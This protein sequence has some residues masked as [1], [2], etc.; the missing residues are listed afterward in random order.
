MSESGGKIERTLIL[1]ID[2][3]DDIGKKGDV[4]TPI[5]S[6]NSNLEAATKLALSDP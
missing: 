2:V 3:D 4:E 5:L 6:R 1:C